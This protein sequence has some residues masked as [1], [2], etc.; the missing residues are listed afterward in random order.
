MLG[1]DSRVA[2]YAW[3]A[4]APAVMIC[5]AYLLRRTLFVFVIALMFAYLLYPLADKIERRVSLNRRASVLAL[6]FILILSLL[7]GLGVFLGRQASTEAA[8]LM[9]K[10]NSPDF[11]SRVKAWEPLGLPLGEQIAKK[12][13]EFSGRSAPARSREE[14]CERFAWV[15]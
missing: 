6:P 1:V 9:R 12:L 7:G 2:R 3:S 14:A 11:V 4:T 8:Q 15:A 5:T 13:D 10:T